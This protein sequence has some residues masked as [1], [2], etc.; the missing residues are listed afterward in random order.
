MDTFAKDIMDVIP[1]EL[2]QCI[3]CATPGMVRPMLRSVCSLWS[4][5]LAQ[6]VVSLGMY[7]T[8]SGRAPQTPLYADSGCRHA[9]INRR[10]CA[11]HYAKLAIDRGWWSVVEWMLDCAGP[12]G[13]I[14][15]LDEYACHPL[16]RSDNDRLRLEQW[17]HRGGRTWHRSTAWKYAA[18][19]G[20]LALLQQY[21]DEPLRTRR[22]EMD[23]NILFAAA[24]SGGHIP[25]MRWLRDCGCAWPSF[26]LSKPAK[27]GHL[28]AVAWMIQQGCPRD[29]DVT[30][31]AAEGGN[32]RLIE[33]L[34]DNGF[35]PGYL[36]S[37]YAVKAGHFDALRWIY[38]HGGQLAHT[39]H[40][41]AIAAGRLDMLE[42]LMGK[43][44][45]Y[46]VSL[47]ESAARENQFDIL[48]WLSE[49]KDLVWNKNVSRCAAGTGNLRMLEWL[50]AKGCPLGDDAYISAAQANRLD[51][52][53]WLHKRGCSP[54]C[55][56]I[57][58]IAAEHDNLP[59]LQWAH[60]HG[61][62]PNSKDVCADA[63]KNGNLE[64]LQWARANG[65][66]WNARVCAAA[67]ASGHLNI[68]Q[69]AHENGCLWDGNA[70]ANA[71]QRGHLF[72]LKWLRAHGCPWDFVTCWRAR[73]YGQLEVI[74]WIT[75]EGCPC[76]DQC[77]AGFSTQHIEVREWARSR[78]SE[79][80]HVKQ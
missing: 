38:A 14:N 46:T 54:T 10:R 7:G 12:F 48:V 35:K 64:M 22:K 43:S 19:R 15:D 65:F 36:A 47:C 42:W 60:A 67:A 62:P 55:G 71:A 40:D 37:T 61:C 34:L 75:E 6:P 53:E 41:N 49:R 72:L 11:I 79:Q 57:C 77:Y 29:R 4:A 69:W 78:R 33:W 26:A 27:A 13:S 51:I 21:L 23:T 52:F 24:A 17:T 80:E 3:L 20:D 5:L 39:V 74:Q 63:A 30:V 32:I 9:C 70:C 50:H 73:S 8:V 16:L 59:M 25:V 58:S 68:I 56:D 66:A 44:R 2:V 76:D 28:D 1:P 45:A 31:Y 18:R